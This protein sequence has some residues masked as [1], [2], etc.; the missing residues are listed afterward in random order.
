[1]SNAFNFSGSSKQEW[2]EKISADLKD[3]V[4]SDLIKTV[5]GLN[6][7]PAIKAEDLH[8]NFAS[9][10]S[11][12]D[13][14]L[15]IPHGEAMSGDLLEGVDIFSS[16][17]WVDSALPLYYDGIG[18]PSEGDW[19][20]ENI[21]INDPSYTH[22]RVGRIRISKEEQKKGF[23][24]QFCTEL[25]SQSLKAENLV[26]EVNAGTDFFL[27]V[28]FIRSL[29]LALE[30]VF[31]GS[32]PTIVCRCEGADIAEGEKDYTNLLR[33]TTKAMASVIGGTD[34]LFLTS[35]DGRNTADGLRWS[36]NISHLLRY[37]SHLSGISDA[38][39]GSYSVEQLCTQ[40]LEGCEVSLSASSSITDTAYTSPEG[41]RFHKRYSNADTSDLSHLD[42]ISGIPPYLRGP[43]SSMYRIRPWTI[44]QYAG[45]STA[46]E[47]NAFYRRN[48]AAGQKGLSVAFDL[49]THRGYDSDHERV[50]GDVGMA[51]V[52]IDTVEDMKILFDQIP[53]DVMSVSM[54]M[55]GAVLPILAFYI[56]AAE[57]QGVKPEQLKG[58]IQN[59]ILKRKTDRFLPQPMK[60]FRPTLTQ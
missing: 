24:G 54:T 2:V 35:F 44:R 4:Y 33:L 9:L 15:M 49:A 6:I 17:N 43:Y 45:F 37:E 52:A 16:E 22:D 5:N 58:T 18:A 23:L 56:I 51:G 11:P 55:N 60:N 29:R 7:E 38:I 46:E 36:R 19:S 42:F 26:V 32:C 39:A 59:D 48:L 40:W 57:E 50:Y 14:K 8:G 21:D 41:I 20:F 34:I 27:H 47:S 30:S 53:L 10:T 1:M 12:S 28:S 13:W 3:G 31:D 25:K